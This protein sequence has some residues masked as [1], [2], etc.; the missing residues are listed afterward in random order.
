MVKRH[1]GA[2]PWLT[3]A[4]GVEKPFAV[5]RLIADAC[6]GCGEAACGCEP[7]DAYET[8]VATLAVIRAAAAS[9]VVA[10]R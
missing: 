10:A 5:A 7:I 2:R 8:D 1:A 4:V 9:R 6:S 3:A